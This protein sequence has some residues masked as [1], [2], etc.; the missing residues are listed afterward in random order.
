MHTFVQLWILIYKYL[1]KIFLIVFLYHLSFRTI[2]IITTYTYSGSYFKN[3]LYKNIVRNY[4]NIIIST[5]TFKKC[6][7]Y[8]R[9]IL[10]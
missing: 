2:Y 5:V 6:L 4:F 1:L 3:Y 9:V 7:F 8:K 10:G